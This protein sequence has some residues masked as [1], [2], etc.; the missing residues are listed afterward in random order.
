MKKAVVL[1]FVLVITFSLAA[2]DTSLNAMS[3]NGATGIYVV[4]TARI[5]FPDDTIGFNAGYHTNFFRPLNGDLKMNHLLQANF[6]FLKMIEVSGTFDFQ[7]DTYIDHPNDFI[8]GVK[9]QLPVG[10]VPIA[11]G[12]N[13]QYHNLGQDNTDHW[14]FQIYGAVTYQAEL[15]GWPA[16][17]TLMVGHTFIEG[18]NSNSNIDFGM[19]FDLI[20]FPKQLNDF[21]HL[22]IDFS[23]FSYSAGPWGADAWG[24]GVFN[25]GLRVDFS[26]IPALNKFTFAVDA[27]LADAF[28]SSKDNYFGGGRSFGAGVVFG[29]SF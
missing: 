7:P 14:A 13:F 21:L 24:R 25:T 10:S 20:I 1:L 12:G 3:L 9:F 22:L 8:T 11:F 19:G 6:S 23:N 26:R 4:P 18:N 5:G 15:F 27:F 16:D 2:Q 17:T 29:M 28:D